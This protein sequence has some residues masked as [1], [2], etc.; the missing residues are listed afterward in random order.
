MNIRRRSY[1]VTAA[2]AFGWVLAG[3]CCLA[4]WVGG[5]A[6]QAGRT[7]ISPSEQAARDTERVRILDAE[8]AQEQQ[9][10]DEAARRRAERLAA[11]DAAA[12][13]DAE[14]ARARHLENMAALRREIGAASAPPR[15]TG[16]D[17]KPSPAGMARRP[18]DTTP[19]WDVYA[20]PRPL[21]PPPLQSNASSVPPARP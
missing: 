14:Q 5:A 20:R 6:A 8:L 10:A 13:D 19:W 21:S 18:P 4:G 1:Q 12:A 3:L 16:S 17:I 7:V 11:G 2:L 9:R 15:T